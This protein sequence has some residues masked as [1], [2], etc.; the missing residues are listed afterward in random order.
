MILAAHAGADA[1]LAYSTFGMFSEIPL[2]NALSPILCNVNRW[3]K[4]DA[5]RKISCKNASSTTIG[6][7][8]SSKEISFLTWPGCSDA[9]FVILLS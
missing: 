4:A 1:L 8:T 5:G 2:G 7:Y 9:P 6:H 3:V